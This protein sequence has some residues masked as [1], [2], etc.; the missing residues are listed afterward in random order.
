MVEHA[1]HDVGER[2]AKVEHDVAEGVYEYPHRAVDEVDGDEVS[3]LSAQHARQQHHPA[4]VME[5]RAQHSF[6]EVG[7]RHL[8]RGR[9]ASGR[10]QV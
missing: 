3:L 6:L 2:D 10:R 9:Q 5:D 1:D 7:G 8:A 4:R